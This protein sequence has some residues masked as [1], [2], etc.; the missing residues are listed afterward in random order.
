MRQDGAP[1]LRVKV[2]NHRSVF[3]G[4]LPLTIL[5]WQARRWVELI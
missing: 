4:I 5:D 2:T 1:F 3:L